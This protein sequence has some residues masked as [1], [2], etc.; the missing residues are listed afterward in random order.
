ME[1]KHSRF[2][3]DH[4]GICGLGIQDGD[5]FEKR[6]AENEGFEIEKKMYGAKS[7]SEAKEERRSKNQERD[8]TLPSSPKDPHQCV[9]QSRWIG[10]VRQRYF[11][12]AHV[13]PL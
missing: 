2:I 5:A 8:E 6:Q 7:Y 12:I 9:T 1:I 4:K 11:S 10:Q 3:Q 13:P